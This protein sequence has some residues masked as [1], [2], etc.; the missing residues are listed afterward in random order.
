ME[1]IYIKLD[2]D[3][4]EKI[5][6]DKAKRLK[7]I[8]YKRVQNIE[9]AEDIVQNTME[10]IC[11]IVNKNNRI[12]NL[13]A[14]V[15][16]ILKYRCIDIFR[17]N[18]SMQYFSNDVLENYLIEEEVNTIENINLYHVLN[19][20]EELDM[21]LIIYKFIYGF[22]NTEISKIFGCCSQTVARKINKALEV[23]R[24]KLRTE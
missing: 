12:Y 23:M 14:W 19:D 22:N 7:R 17:K 18:N 4:V 21:K 8:A 5:Y 9:V 13:D 15:N 3:L 24:N 16:T 2:W 20:L 1:N 11:K 10:S 6:I